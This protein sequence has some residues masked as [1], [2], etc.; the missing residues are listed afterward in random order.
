M[1]KRAASMDSDE[2][3]TKSVKISDPTLANAS[4]GLNGIYTLTKPVRL[5]GLH[6]RAACYN[7]CSTCRHKVDNNWPEWQLTGSAHSIQ[8]A[9]LKHITACILDQTR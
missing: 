7:G 2:G 6:W 3:K 1:A 9:H 4:T 5:V 8:L